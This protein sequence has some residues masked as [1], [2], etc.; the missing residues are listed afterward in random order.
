MGNTHLKTSKPKRKRRGIGRK[1][2]KKNDVSWKG[3][4]SLLTGSDQLCPGSGYRG[5]GRGPSLQVYLLTERRK[6]APGAGK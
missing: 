2:K 6:R 3:K 5:G 1:G 4:L